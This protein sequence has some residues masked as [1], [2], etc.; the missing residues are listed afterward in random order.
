M[1]KV[2]IAGFMHSNKKS[3]LSEFM[4]HFRNIECENKKSMFFIDDNKELEIILNRAKNF[5]FKVKDFNEKKFEGIY[6]ILKEIKEMV[7]KDG[8]EYVF[9]LNHCTLCPPTILNDLLESKKNI[10]ASAFFQPLFEKKNDNIY[11]NRVSNAYQFKHESEKNVSVKPLMF[12]DLLPSQ[13]Q[14]V[15]MILLNAALIHRS[16]LEK[17]DFDK[18]T[19]QM[20]P[21]LFFASE[22]AQLGEDIFVDSRNVS[23]MLRHVIVNTLG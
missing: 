8:F 18:A 2:L 12:N 19:L 3:L 13:L 11:R 17:I 5:P 21:E 15:D 9:L 6:G 23:V 4:H 7:L 16:V 1:N 14:K 20:P 22:C 10:V